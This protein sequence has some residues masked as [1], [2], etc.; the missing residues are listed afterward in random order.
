MGLDLTKRYGWVV[1]WNQE[2]RVNDK[3]ECR[4]LIIDEGSIDKARIL[5]QLCSCQPSIVEG[6]AYLVKST[7]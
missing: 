1:L 7:S 3:K 6:I 4:K 2:C 5:C